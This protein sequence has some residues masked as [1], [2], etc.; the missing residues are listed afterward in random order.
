MHPL[1]GEIASLTRDAYLSAPVDP[2]K[3]KFIPKIHDDIST[4]GKRN[5][6][7]GE[8]LNELLTQKLKQLFP[9]VVS[10]VTALRAKYDSNQDTEAEFQALQELPS[11]LLVFA[12]QLLHHIGPNGIDIDF[13]KFCHKRLA[14]N[15]LAIFGIHN[16]ADVTEDRRVGTEVRW[17]PR[18]GPDRRGGEDN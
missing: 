5:P 1:R 14:N 18:S 9:E 12:W 7:L 4:A 17:R 6:L 16:A 15:I 13:A 10:R 11:S 2:T 8:E 3:G